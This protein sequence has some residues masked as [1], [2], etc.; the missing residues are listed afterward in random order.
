MNQ[1]ESFNFGA[2]FNLPGSIQTV[3]RGERH[4]VFSTHKLATNY[5]TSFTT[6][7]NKTSD[8][9]HKGPAAGSSSNSCDTWRFAL[10]I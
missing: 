6:D 10:L 4:V 7:S 5:V 8:T 1:D 3:G 2:S 9:F